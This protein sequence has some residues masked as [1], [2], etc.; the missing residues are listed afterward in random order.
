M[1]NDFDSK[2]CSRRLH[3]GLF[4]HQK[5]WPE[6]A[7]HDELTELF[8]SQ[9]GETQNSVEQPDRVVEQSQ[10]RP[11]AVNAHATFRPHSRSPSAG[12][13]RPAE[14]SPAA[15]HPSEPGVARPAFKC[16][17]GWRLP[18]T[19]LPCRTSGAMAAAT[20]R[21]DSPTGVATPQSRAPWQ[22]S[23][24]N[25]TRPANSQASLKMA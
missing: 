4:L 7:S 5:G 11:L 15:N 14:N 24:G 16:A 12:S 19:G 1:R 18:L 21:R 20:N 13:T 6:P 23:Q 22:R 8:K 2:L 9:L 25:K 10:A 17:V 3:K